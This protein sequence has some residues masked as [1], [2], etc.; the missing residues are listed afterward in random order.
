VDA[1]TFFFAKKKVTKEKALQKRKQKRGIVK[2]RKK[3]KKVLDFSFFMC[4]NV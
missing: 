3:F 2:N 1:V 4:Y